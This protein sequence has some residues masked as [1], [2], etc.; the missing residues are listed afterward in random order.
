[1]SNR[2]SQVL[3]IREVEALEDARYRAWKAQRETG[4]KEAGE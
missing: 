4:G 2:L 1:M 3:D